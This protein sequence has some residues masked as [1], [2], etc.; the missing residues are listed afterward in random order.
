MS[1]PPKREVYPAVLQHVG[2][3]PWHARWWGLSCAGPALGKS[4]EFSRA[5]GFL[6]LASGW[7]WRG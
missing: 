6:R 4:D 3:L 5:R 1:D 2:G 7:A